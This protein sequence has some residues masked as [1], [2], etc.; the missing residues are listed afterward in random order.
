MAHLAIIYLPV[1]KEKR[2]GILRVAIS[3]LPIDG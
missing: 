2:D 3:T 1:L